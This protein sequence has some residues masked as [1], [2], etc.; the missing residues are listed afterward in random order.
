M[1]HIGYYALKR[2]LVSPRKGAETIVFLAS[3]P[4]VEGISGKYFFRNREVPS[5]RISYDEDAAKR[6]W[7]LSLHMTGLDD[8]PG[9]G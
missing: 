4:A 8:R 5:S 9:P 6:L 1:R 3:S 7:E 2:E